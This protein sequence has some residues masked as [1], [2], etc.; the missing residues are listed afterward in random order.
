MGTIS[1]NYNST[2]TTGTAFV[3]SNGFYQL[4]TTNTL[5]CQRDVTT[6][7]YVPN[8][9]FI[10]ARVNSTAANER[11]ILTFVIH[12]E[13]SST[14]P[15]SFP[16]PGFGIDEDVEGTLTS[17]VQVLRS[18]NNVVIPVPSATTTSIG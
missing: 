17:L 1:F 15:P 8:K 3:V 11:R 10:L 13:D 5:I 18:D 6:S 7:A 12:W 9:Y 14:A 16:D 2:K 4:S